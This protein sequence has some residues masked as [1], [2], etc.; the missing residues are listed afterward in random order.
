MFRYTTHYYTLSPSAMVGHLYCTIQ[1]MDIFVFN[2]KNVYVHYQQLHFGSTSKIYFHSSSRKS[3]SFKNFML[4]QEI[5]I[6][7]TKPHYSFRNS[8]FL[9]LALIISLFK[10]QAPEHRRQTH[11]TNLPI[12]TPADLKSLHIIHRGHSCQK[13]GQGIASEQLILN[14]LE[15]I[16][17]LLNIC[18]EE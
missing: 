3:Y 13:G 12:P 17:S 10:N 9:T 6:H 11:S 14:F 2:K 18:E 8:S 4:I 16:L 15:D 1:E 7:L 5:G